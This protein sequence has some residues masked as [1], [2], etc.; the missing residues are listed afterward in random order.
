MKFS[1]EWWA[2]YAHPENRCIAHP[3]NREQCRLPARA[4]ATV[5]RV[6]G[7]AAPQVIAKARE[8]LALAADR[9]AHELLGIATGA[10]SEVVKLQA[11]KDALDRAGL[12]AKQA[13]E[14]SAKPLAPWE[15]VLRDVSFASI[16]RAE[17]RAL[18][19]LRD[20]DLARAAR[21]LEVLDAEVVP[22]QKPRAYG[23]RATVGDAD[24]LGAAEG[25]ADK[26]ATSLAPVAAPRALTQD[27]AAEVMRES[28]KRTG[29]IRRKA[30]NRRM[31]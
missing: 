5:C 1:E 9:M 24:R 20:G 15:E 8:R 19:A 23:P 25:P 26:S 29:Q 30:R 3:K 12:S 6:H 17:H 18:G 13:L 4:G 7:G 10:E 2:N 14:L 22:L 27:E 16:T 31:R 11:V 28:R 21:E